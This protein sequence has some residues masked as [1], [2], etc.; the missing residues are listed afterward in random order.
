[1]ETAPRTVQRES[2]C[3]FNSYA[4]L[5]QGYLVAWL[6]ARNRALG[7]DLVAQT[8][9]NERPDQFFCIEI[10]RE[11][12]FDPAC[13]VQRFQLVGGEHQVEACE[14]VLQLRELSRSDN[15]DDRH[16]SVTEPR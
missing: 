1:M 15:G 6:A 8:A 11:A 13:L 7:Q 2:L 5:G 14:V 16:G 10:M 12:E 3:A 9:I 4:L